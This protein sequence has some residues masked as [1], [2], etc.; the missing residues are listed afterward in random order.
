MK[1]TIISYAFSRL[2]AQGKT[3]I[4][5]YLESIKSRFG[6]TGADVWNGMLFPPAP[7]LGMMES[8]Q[9]MLTAGLDADY[10]AK[11]KDALC[12]RELELACLAC[13]LCHVWEDDPERREALNKNAWAHIEAGEKLGAKTIRIDAGASRMVFGGPPLEM[14]YTDEQ[15]DYIV[16]MFKKYAQRAY[17][18][19]YKIGPENHWGPEDVPEQLVKIC[20]AVDSSAFGVLLHIGRWRGEQAAQGDEMIAPWVMH[21]HVTPATSE[22]DTPAKMAMLRDAGFDGYYSAE[23]V[24]D[25]YAELGVQIARIKSVLDRWR[26]E[27]K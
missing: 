18:S 17:D 16:A 9:R 15:F 5:G 6:L 8:F 22:A 19:G 24:S 26:I 10:L 11:I 25:S 14:E 12:E 23:L 13:D 1:V 7:G 21:A 27:G 2:M 3:D 20:Q 4:F